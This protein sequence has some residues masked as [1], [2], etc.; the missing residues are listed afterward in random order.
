MNR[1][2]NKKLITLLAT[3]LII[4]AS[5]IGTTF[6]YNNSKTESL[7]NTFAIGSVETEIIETIDDT[8][9]TNN[10]N[11]T[12]RNVGNSDC[13][14]RARITISPDNAK[15]DFNNL[16]LSNWEKIGEYY[17][18]NKVVSPLEPNN[19]TTSL[20]TGVTVDVNKFVPFEITIYQEAVQAEVYNP[21]S[22]KHVYTMTEAWK[23]YDDGTKLAP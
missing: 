15:V 16:A 10:K 4:F 12:I 8:D 5:V 2:K 20:F 1:I 6:A 22:G 23:I 7:T 3:T 21:K 19:E 11:V 17:Y 9:N 14:I 13:Y 18:Y